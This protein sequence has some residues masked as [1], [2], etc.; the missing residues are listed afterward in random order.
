MDAE[1][2]SSAYIASCRTKGYLSESIAT[3]G[4]INYLPW[5]LKSFPQASAKRPTMLTT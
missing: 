3:T 2:R 4:P 1:I 5:V